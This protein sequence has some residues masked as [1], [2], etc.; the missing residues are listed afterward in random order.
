MVQFN[1]VIDDMTR[2]IAAAD[3]G[4]V[5]TLRRRLQPVLPEPLLS[6]SIASLAY[7]VEQ[8]PATLRDFA[9]AVSAS[10]S[11]SL[12]QVAIG[13]FQYLVA[14]DD[15]LPDDSNGMLGYLDDAWLIHNAAYRCVASQLLGVQQFSVNWNTIAMA[16]SLAMQLFPPQVKAALEGIAAQYSNLVAGEMRQF[17]PAPSADSSSGKTIDDYYFTIGGTAYLSTKPIS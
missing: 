8:A 1:A 17:Q 12:Q 13:L 4:P 6:Q 10:G 2:R 3:R 7:Y 15:L 11:A 16:D 14:P 9:A 5:D